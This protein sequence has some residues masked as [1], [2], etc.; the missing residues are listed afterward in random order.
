MILRP[1][2]A[3]TLIEL[4]VVIAIIAVLI[5]LLLPAVQSA[6]EAARRIQCTNNLK[7]IGL[8][9]HNYH[10]GPEFV[11]VGIRPEPDVRRRARRPTVGLGA[12][13][14]LLLVAPA[15]HRGG[16]ALQFDEFLLRGR[17]RPVQHHGHLEHHQHRSSARRT[18]ISSNRDCNCNYAACYG[19]TTDSMTSTGTSFRLDASGRLPGYVRRQHGAVRGGGDLLDRQLHRRHIEHRRLRRDP[20]RRQQG[21]GRLHG[22]GTGH[23]ARRARIVGTSSTRRIPCVKA[24]RRLDEPGGDLGRAP[25]LRHGHAAPGA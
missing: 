18:R 17:L 11:P 12:Q 5:A 21:D 1:R 6:R 9:I 14:E 19:T 15:L 24:P 25:G 2:R 4:L 3:F 16:P 20:G 23:L 22:R 13:P 7:Q 10:S 8:A